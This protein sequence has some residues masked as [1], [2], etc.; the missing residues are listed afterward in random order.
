MTIQPATNSMRQQ[1]AVEPTGQMSEVSCPDPLNLEAQFL[2]VLATFSLSV[3]TAFI[4]NSP[5]L[6]LLHMSFH[7][8]LEAVEHLSQ[9]NLAF[10]Q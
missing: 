7:H 2:V 1:L 8:R 10:H 9:L 5:Q 6:K 3:L 4:P